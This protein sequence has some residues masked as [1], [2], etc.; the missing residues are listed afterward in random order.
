MIL[1]KN[2]EGG[3]M[4]GLKLFKIPIRIAKHLIYLCG[5]LDAKNWATVQTP[6]PVIYAKKRRTRLVFLI[7]FMFVHAVFFE[8]VLY[9]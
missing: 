6:K 8:L 7:P 2:T 5:L 1:L 4:Y 3:S 9:N